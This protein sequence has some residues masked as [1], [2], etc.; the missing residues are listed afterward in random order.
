[1]IDRDEVVR[2]LQ[3]LGNSGDPEGAHS[4]ADD[5][6]IEVLRQIGYSDIADAWDAVPKCC[7]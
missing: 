7:A 1:M 5:I 6:L 3:E 2:R 4:M